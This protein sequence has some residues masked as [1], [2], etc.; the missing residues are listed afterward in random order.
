MFNTI[1]VYL[2]RLQRQNSRCAL[3]QV[4][5]PTCRR[6]NTVLDWNNVQPAA[7]KD[8]FYGTIALLKEE[9]SLLHYQTRVECFGENGKVEV[10][11][12]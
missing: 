12:E 6:Q 1:D 4:T 7:F 2:D 10:S 3:I 8:Y 11:G 9:P 5:Q